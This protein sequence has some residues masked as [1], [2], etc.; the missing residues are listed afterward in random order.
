MGEG[1]VG[2]ASSLRAIQELMHSEGAASQ[3]LSCE[4]QNEGSG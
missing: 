3:P 1:V 2:A 4:G